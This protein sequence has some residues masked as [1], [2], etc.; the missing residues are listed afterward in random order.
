M[1]PFHLVAVVIVHCIFVVA[2]KHNKSSEETNNGAS[3]PAE[4]PEAEIKTAAVPLDRI[5]FNFEFSFNLVK[6]R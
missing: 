6:N 1:S 3:N 4:V 5:R 2:T